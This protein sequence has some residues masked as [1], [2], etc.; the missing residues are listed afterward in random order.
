MCTR[1]Q[2]RMIRIIALIVK[3]IKNDITNNNDKQQISNKLPFSGSECNL[4][5]FC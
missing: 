5:L 2:I 4:I 1:V 3:G